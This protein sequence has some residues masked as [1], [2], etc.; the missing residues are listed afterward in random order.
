MERCKT[1]NESN[2]MERNT[3]KMKETQWKVEAKGREFVR[4]KEAKLKVAIKGELIIE[5]VIKY[6]VTLRNKQ[7]KPDLDSKNIKGK[8]EKSVNQ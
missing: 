7:I 2:E 4:E 5:K 1:W 3:M 8:D 6:K